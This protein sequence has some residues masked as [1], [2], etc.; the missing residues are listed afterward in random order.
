MITDIHN[1]PIHEALKENGYVIVDNLI[2]QD[3]FT[4]L[5]EACDRVVDKARKGEWKYRRLVGTQF[6]PWTEGT[7]VWGV[8]H[9]LHPDLNEPIFAQW[10]G[11]CKLLEAVQQLL[12]AKH[13]EL[14]L[15]LFNLLINPQESDF[16]LTWHRDAIPAETK[17]EDEREKLTIPHYGTQWNTALYDDACLYVV[18]NSHRRVRTAEERDVTINDPKSSKM[19]GQL[20]VE[21][22]AGQTVF[23]D[24]NILHRA[25][26]V[27]SQKRAT[28]HA[29]M[30]TIE[31][32]H[33]RAS[34]ILQHGL[35]WMQTDEFKRSLPDSLC[36][37]FANLTAMANKA[38]MPNL[39]AKPI[40]EK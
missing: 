30:G 24:N 40:H 20:K 39:C 18:P 3:M 34:C 19:P 7:D 23:Y 28:L 15:E 25:S 36:V 38:G 11:S 27:S 1:R 31:G 17:E 32:G 16:D 29:S 21:L 6:P 33:Y 8:Q 14:Q 10:Y 9:L 5:R 26:Y 35:E 13:E 22:K 4:K 2:P 12:N 37:P